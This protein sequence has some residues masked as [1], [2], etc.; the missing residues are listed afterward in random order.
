MKKLA[1]SLITCIALIG[2]MTGTIEGKDKGL[3]YE[4]SRKISKSYEVNSNVRLSIEN[5]F[6]RVHINTWDQNKMTVDIE[7]IARMN[8]ESRAQDL[9]DRI[10]VDIEE[11]NSEISFET[12]LGNLKNR[13][14]EEFEINYKVNM[15][16]KNP[17]RLKNSFGSNFIA[18][19]TGQSNIDISYGDFRIEKLFGLTNIKISF[20]DGAI[21][22]VKEGEI[23]VKYSDMEINELGVVKM[24]QGFSDVEIEK[25]GTI[26]LSS[27]YG[28]VEIGTVQGIKGYVGYSEFSIDRLEV[29]LDMEAQYSG[30]F[31][32]NEVAK[33]FTKILIDGKF[34]DY[35]I[36]FEEVANFTFETE[37]SFSDFSYS[38]L[39]LDFDQKIKKDFSAY[40]KGKMG[41]GK[42]GYVNI[43][44]S[45]GD[46][47]F[48]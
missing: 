20:S 47:R 29:E 1:F 44:T 15:P 11:S 8:N 35:R 48:R 24:E 23:E 18:D 45:Y 37:L 25:I 33:D 39:P 14:R 27:K 46:I 12:R 30:G 13:D 34:G 36:S 31:T 3:D 26:D 10:K 6:G 9:L 43:D 22:L 32:I 5:T 41:S 42:G 28:D 4:K 19:L 40:Y 21:Q 2:F 16:K 17:L 38:G 7:I